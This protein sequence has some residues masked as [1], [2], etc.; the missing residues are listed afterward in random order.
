[1]TYWYDSLLTVSENL[2][3]NK[4]IKIYDSGIIK[5]MMNLR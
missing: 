3:K 4:I 2:I 1:M 5:Y